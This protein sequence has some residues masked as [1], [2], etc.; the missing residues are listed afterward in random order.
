V[1]KLIALQVGRVSKSASKPIPTGRLKAV[2][3]EASL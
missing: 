2:G 3:S 1:T